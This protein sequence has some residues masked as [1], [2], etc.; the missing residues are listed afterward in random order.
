[1]SGDA[2]KAI[3]AKQVLILDG[4]TGTELSKRGMPAG[5]CPE[6]WVLEHPET[7]RAVQ[8]DYV[9]A[10]AHCVYAP[11]FG[12]NRCKLA[13]FGRENDVVAINR[14]LALLSREAAPDSLIFGDMAPTGQ[15]IE[16][17]GDLAF[18]DA[19]AIYREQAEGLLAGGVDGFVIET[20]MDIQETRAA[21]LAVREL[22]DLPIMVTM[23]FEKGLR[24]LTGNDPVSALITL[25]ALGVSAFGCN[26]SMGPEGMLEI[27]RLLKPYARVPLIAKPNA[28]LPQWQDGQTVFSMEAETFGAFGPEFVA[29]GAGILGGCCG[30]TPEHIRR[31]ADGLA[32]LQPP[33]VAA[34]RGACVSH[35]RGYRELSRQAPFAVIGERINP[36]GKKALQA[37]LREGKYDLVSRYAD[38]Q[39]AAGAALLDVN[40]GLSGIDELAMM[41]E[42]VTMLAQDYAV[43]LCIDTTRADVAE[44]ALRCYPGRALFN[45]ISAEKDRLE[46]VLPVAAKYGAML[47]LLP[48]TDEGIPATLEERIDVIKRIFAEAQKYGYSKDDVCVDGLVMTVSA[49]PEA[50]ELTLGL[51]EWCARGWGVNCVCGLSNVSFGLPRRDLI[52]RAFLGMAIGRGLN[53]AIANPTLADIMETVAAGDVLCGRDV[54]MQ[55]FLSRYGSS[56]GGKGAT[57]AVDAGAAATPEESV[58]KALLAGDTAGIVGAISACIQAGG[59]ADHI[60]NEILIPGI[61]EVGDRFERKDFFLPQLIMSADAM[62]AGMDFLTPLLQQE[63]AATKPLGRMIMATVKGDIHDIGKN[64]VAMMLRNYN[65]DVLDLGKDVPAELIL[66]TA[67]REGISIIGLSALMT[68]TMGEM[69]QVVE[70]AAKRGMNSLRFVVGG[71]VVDDNFA[72]SIGAY[73]AGDALATVKIVK[74]LLK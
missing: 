47:I 39:L 68:T 58:R 53:M 4:A 14:D 34:T 32:G 22:C 65:I 56:E 69:K 62:R 38:E 12:G 20:M 41:R 8:G 73:Y 64:I 27:I 1:M 70:L 48:V 13:E 25:Q 3:L 30:T 60:V 50:A 71:A 7:I 42:G 19:V 31:L 55:G 36:T 74:E 43:P 18:E 11:T 66:D 23:T 51:V 5:V 17:V 57:S 54:R 40:F 15:F 72:R 10:G 24:T 49:S 6:L 44:A 52:N 29:A 63:G 37:E 28:G 35:A 33:E 45:S 26:C 9:A 46:E 59:K 16:P 2:F 21:V 61:T 67:A